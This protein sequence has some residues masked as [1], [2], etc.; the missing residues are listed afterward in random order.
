M[1]GKRRWA[2]TETQEVPPEHQE[3]LFYCGSDRALAQVA[4]GDCGVSILGHIQKPSRH[5]P[6]QLALGGPA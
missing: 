4:Q 3:T 5:G 2:Q 1:T 6:G